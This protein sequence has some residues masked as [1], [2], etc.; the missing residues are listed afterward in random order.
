MAKAKLTGEKEIKKIL[1]ELK[2]DFDTKKK[3]FLKK[4][5]KKFRIPDFFLPKY[6]LTIEYFGSWNNPKNKKLQEKERK[7]F[8][9][10]VGAYESSGVNCI[11]LYPD[12][13]VHAKKIIENKINE[14]EDPIKEEIIEQ[15]S[16]KPTQ[17]NVVRVKEE[18]IIIQKEKK[19]P[20][21]DDDYETPIVVKEKPTEDGLKKI[22]IY[23]ISA[24]VILFIA[25]VLMMI[26]TFSIGNPLINPISEI[27]EITYILFIIAGIISIIL[28]IVFA[29]NKD[30][31]K[32]FIIVA[33]ILIAFYIIT[34]FF[35][36]D[37]LTRTITIL[38]TAL[39]IAPSE[40][41]MVTSN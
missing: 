8:M 17:K 39:A 18:K 10:K 38:L 13:L 6:N 16:N 4:D 29:I 1:E 36:G 21:F 33:I 22:I 20:K 23:N 7:R 26:F 9:E 37:P 14:L 3:L 41:Y 5:T 27:Y 31:S 35:F 25:L 11:Y 24:I 19:L 30:L 2:V 28:S 15:V 34:L 40:Y 12:E 32:G